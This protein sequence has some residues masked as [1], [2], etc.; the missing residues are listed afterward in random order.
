MITSRAAILAAF[1]AKLQTDVTGTASLKA[2][3]EATDAVPK[4]GREVQPEQAKDKSIGLTVRTVRPFSG[5][6]GLVRVG[7][8]ATC[9]AKHD[10]NAM[11]IADRVHELIHGPV[12]ETERWFFDFSNSA[13]KVRSATRPRRGSIRYDEETKFFADTV[14]FEATIQVTP[15]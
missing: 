14:S 12:D 6:P 11:K 2:L 8:S 10:V 13:I 4:I 1:S 7:L 3:T 5:S 15:S 9:F